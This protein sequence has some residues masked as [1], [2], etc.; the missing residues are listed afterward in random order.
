VLA[1]L[2]IPFRYRLKLREYA[3]LVVGA[4]ACLPLVILFGEEWLTR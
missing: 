2:V 3:A 4:L 1:A